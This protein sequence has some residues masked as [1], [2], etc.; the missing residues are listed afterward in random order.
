MM[1]A[2]P[3]SAGTTL[4]VDT[5]GD[6]ICDDV[7]PTLIPTSDVTMS[8]QA[9]ALAMTPI[10]G[11]GA[12]DYSTGGTVPSGCNVIGESNF[13]VP[14]SKCVSTGLTYFLQSND[15]VGPLWTV[16]PITTNDCA[17]LQVDT[18][19]RLPPGPTCVITSAVDAAGNHMVS[20][21]IR[22]CVDRGGPECAG[23]NSSSFTATACTGRWDKVAQTHITGTCVEP[24]VAN[25]TSGV[26]TFVKSGEVRDLFSLTH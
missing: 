7:D 22:I 14:N 4:A 19:N 23:F 2:V 20:Y 17:G 16:G 18:L 25:G 15:A 24:P 5:D 9:L 12:P 1:Y 21:P 6:G 10:V 11:G 13:V 3:M 26:H 8:G